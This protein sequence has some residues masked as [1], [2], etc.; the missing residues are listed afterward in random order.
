MP[1]LLI[2]Q[3]LSKPRN[4]PRSLLHRHRPLPHPQLQN[5]RR[6]RTTPPLAH[7]RRQRRNDAADLVVRQRRHPRTIRRELKADTQL[8]EQVRRLVS[9]HAA[10]DRV[11]ERVVVRGPEV[12]ERG[13]GSVD[14]CAQAA[15]G[16]GGRGVGV[17]GG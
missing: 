3:P 2:A 5:R 13:D 8:R 1:T 10:G 7:I 11:V 6:R 17:E 15:E 14:E 4:I 9:E 16:E 12:C